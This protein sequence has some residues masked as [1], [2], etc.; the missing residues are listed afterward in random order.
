MTE[1]KITAVLIIVEKYELLRYQIGVVFTI[2]NLIEKVFNE[3][4]VNTPLV[5]VRPV[6]VLY[7]R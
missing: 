4:L 2:F 3:F 6:V 7:R 1:K 5:A